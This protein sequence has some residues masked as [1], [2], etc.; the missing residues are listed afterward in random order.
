VKALKMVLYLTSMALCLV[1]FLI[2]AINVM[3]NRQELFAFE[4][5]YQLT[6]PVFFLLSCVCLSITPVRV[7][8]VKIRLVLATCSTLLIAMYYLFTLFLNENY[9]NQTTS[10]LFQMDA[11]IIVTL[12]ILATHNL[13]MFLAERTGK[14][15]PHQEDEVIVD[16]LLH[17]LNRP[18][19]K[20]RNEEIEL[21]ITGAPLG[22]STKRWRRTT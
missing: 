6:E 18:A 1:F 12:L 2:S 4:T 22:N 13:V 14:H 5:M 16:P 7:L 10:A 11:W 17:T 9:I 8:P 15:P 19:A 20:S 21:E 3:R